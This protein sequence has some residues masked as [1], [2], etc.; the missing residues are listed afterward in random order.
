MKHI[1]TLV[2]LGA[3]FA[4]S[5]VFAASAGAANTDA[6][7]KR[8]IQI[9]EKD[10]K[11]AIRVNDDDAKGWTANNKPATFAKIKGMTSKLLVKHLVKGIIENDGNGVT[12]AR[13][14]KMK[15]GGWDFIPMPDHSGLG[16]M[17]FAQIGNSDVYFGEWAD[18]KA[19][20]ADGTAGTN[21][22]VYYNGTGRTTNM[23]TSGTATYA[24]KGINNHVAWNTAVLQGDLKADFGRKTLA[25]T[26][27]RATGDLKT[28]GINAYIRPSDASF[29]GNAIANGSVNGTTNGH[30]FGNNA[31]SLAGIAQFD[32]NKKLNAAFGGAKK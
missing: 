1:K 20:A 7:G 15:G 29:S 5:S 22:S 21:R 24:V 28:L 12:V 16:R 4:A 32:N 9:A 25:G 23:P 3:A 18:V 6:S 8:F 13:M 14:Y 11:A 30:F 31:A 26:L 27:T 2:A 19:G 10:G 17:S